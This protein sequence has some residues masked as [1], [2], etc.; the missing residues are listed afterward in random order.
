MSTA[1]VTPIPRVLLQKRP[2]L[3]VRDHV[4]Q[5]RTSK[6]LDPT[7]MADSYEKHQQYLDALNGDVTGII[8]YLQSLSIALPTGPFQLLYIV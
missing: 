6:K 3:D 7:D 1:Q 8:S 4:N 2:A 5:L